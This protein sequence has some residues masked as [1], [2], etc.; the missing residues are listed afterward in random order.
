MKVLFVTT[1]WPFPSQPYR[2]PFVQVLT[3]AIQEKLNAFEVLPFQLR[4]SPVNFI[5]AR[6]EIKRKAKGVDHIHAYGLNS[7]LLIPKRYFGKTSVSLIGSDVYGV[8]GKAGRYS[9]LGKAPL[10]HLRSH[11]KTLAGIRAVSQPLMDLVSGDLSPDQPKIVFTNGMDFGRFK[12][13]DVKEARRL[14]GWTE[15]KYHV[16]F[17]SNPERPV[18]NYQL[19]KDL[20][21]E[22]SSFLDKECELHLPPMGKQER[23]NV[24]YRAADLTLLTS[25][26]EGSPNVV[27]ESLWC[28]TPVFATEVG[29]AP[30]HIH[31]TGLGDTFNSSDDL[32]VA[33]QG[34][35]KWMAYKRGNPINISHYCRRHFD[36]ERATASMCGFWIRI[37]NRHDCEA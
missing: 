15:D 6:Q 1:E 12:E 5:K 20:M 24:M 26:H 8:V 31:A 9:T 10:M 28:G 36:V 32:T 3:T 7:L 30:V 33:G 17:P 21:E 4:R 14:T 35:A 22:A 13:M 37:T 27:K 11:L 29:D 34:M 19:A 18:K 16:F 23:L 25:V 2:A